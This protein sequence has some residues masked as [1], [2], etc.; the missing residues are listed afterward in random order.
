MDQGTLE[1]LERGI[2]WW[3]NEFDRY[4]FSRRYQ[5]VAGHYLQMVW[6]STRYVG[7]GFGAC[8][9]GTMVVCNYWPAVIP[10]S[11]PYE[12]GAPCSNCDVD[13]DTC[14]DGALCGG[15]MST[16]VADRCA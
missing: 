2:A 1:P 13:R 4:N 12:T 7:C 15:C 10:G 3:F 11:Y 5:S 16:A 14:V 9:F 8:D 6:Q